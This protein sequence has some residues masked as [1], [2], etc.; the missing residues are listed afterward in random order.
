MQLGDLGS[1]LEPHR[2]TTNS[3]RPTR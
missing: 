1:C 2:I 3:V